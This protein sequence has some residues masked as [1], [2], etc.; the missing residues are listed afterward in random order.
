MRKLKMNSI[1]KILAITIA[2]IMIASMVT[3]TAVATW[4]GPDPNP[5]APPEQDPLNN[6]I[7]LYGD[8]RPQ[9]NAPD[10]YDN[11][12]KVF[13]PTVIPKDSATFNP[14]YIDRYWSNGAIT[15]DGVN[16]R[17]KIFLRSWYEP[18]GE[19]NGSRKI[20]IYPTINFEYTYML[21]STNFMPIHGMAPTTKFA[22][23]IA[24][25][26]T[27]SGLGA[28]ENAEGT[29]THANVV[30][31]ASVMGDVTPYNKTMKGTIALEKL[32]DLAAMDTV[33][34]L[35]HK[36]QFVGTQTIV[37]PPM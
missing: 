16:A 4:P 32:Y 28:F 17:E 22:F 2:A 15:V 30:T 5:P 35:D 18:C 37:G 13:D 21:M 25:I 27:Q 12:T 9:G 10:T 24:E 31:L 8:V 19:Y 1:G 11:W 6:S 26:P 34:F 33:Q 20:H 29:P 14:A 23:P 36:L 3:L 7:R